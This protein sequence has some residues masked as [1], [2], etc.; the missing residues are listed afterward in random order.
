MG[1]AVSDSVQRDNWAVL[2][3]ESGARVLMVNNDQPHSQLSPA[4]SENKATL[5]YECRVWENICRHRR[6]KSHAAE[7]EIHKHAGGC[8]FSSVRVR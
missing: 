4:Y 5:I 3:Q 1:D 8:L 6:V 7:I 2:C